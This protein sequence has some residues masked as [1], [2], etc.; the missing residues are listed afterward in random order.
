MAVTT[1]AAASAGDLVLVV[2][3]G[4]SSNAATSCT[5]SAGNTYTALG[6]VSV[7]TRRVTAFW[8][9]IASEIA[10]GGSVTITYS[11]ATGVKFGAIYKVSGTASSPADIDGGTGAS[12]TSSTNPSITT[13]TLAQAN[14]IVFAWTVVIGDAGSDSFT[15][16]ADFTAL[17]GVTLAGA[18]GG[19]L[20][21][22]YRIV[23]ATTAV[24]YAPT[25][26]TARDWAVNYVAFKG[27]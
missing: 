21:M 2:C 10:S 20:R 24:T 12:G 15:Q 23:S 7:G 17:T 6:T 8:S 18:S 4:G 1:S 27:N 14:E 5:D 25:L 3:H 11:S 13:G 22:A 19:V 9:R 16:A 26:G